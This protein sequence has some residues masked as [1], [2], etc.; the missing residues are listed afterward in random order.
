[1]VHRLLWRTLKPTVYLG[2][3]YAVV[4]TYGC[5]DGRIAPTRCAIIDAGLD[6]R[7]RPR[8]ACRTP[9]AGARSAHSG[10]AV[11]SKLVSP[12]DHGGSPRSKTIPRSRTRSC[13]DASPAR[14][15]PD[16]RPCPLHPCRVGSWLQ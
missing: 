14:C 8:R 2:V 10:L 4:D 1:M 11:G 12:P 6:G 9:P 5:D 7:C 16:T 13:G 3:T 15:A